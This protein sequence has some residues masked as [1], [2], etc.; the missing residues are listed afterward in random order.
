[1]PI[2]NLTDGDGRLRD[3]AS[4]A[5][6]GYMA[7]PMDEKKRDFLQSFLG[8]RTRVPAIPMRPIL[9]MIAALVSSGAIVE[10]SATYARD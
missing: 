10:S 3:N 9:H 1:M 6:A 5:L 2:M 8:N 7:Y 4:F